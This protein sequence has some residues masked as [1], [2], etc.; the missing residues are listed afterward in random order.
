MS[1]ADWTTA[2]A[3]LFAAVAAFGSWFAAKKSNETALELAKIERDRRQE[4]LLPHFDASMYK[5]KNGQQF[6]KLTLAG[7]PSVLV[8]DSLSVRT[9]GGG[10][11]WKSNTPE[12]HWGKMSEYAWGPFQFRPGISGNV[13][14]TESAEFQ[15]VEQGTPLSIP[16]EKSVAPPWFDQGSWDDR[17]GSQPMRLAVHC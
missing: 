2:S 17:Y 14:A 8:L 11:D 10:L 3:T 7:P 6:L 5:E 1:V 4:E 12:E 13:S 15:D 16:V 9:R